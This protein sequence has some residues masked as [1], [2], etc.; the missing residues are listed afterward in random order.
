MSFY[1]RTGIQVGTCP[2]RTRQTGASLLE[3]LIAILVMSFGVT[4]VAL[5]MATTMQYNK[6]S[7]YQMVAWQIATQLAESMRSNTDGFMADAYLKTDSYSGSR[8]AASEPDCAVSSACTSS[9]IASKDKAKTANNL[10]LSLPGGDFNVV[11]NG[12]Q[13]DIWIM[14]MEPTTAAS[15]SFGGGNCR[16][17]AISGITTP[18]RCLYWRA[19]L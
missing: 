2:K 5:L 14:W 15:L 1:P 3:V 12:K 4:G 17:A 18:P 6:T 13:A 10:R 19:A 11:R 9:E 8:Q 7:Q 16:P